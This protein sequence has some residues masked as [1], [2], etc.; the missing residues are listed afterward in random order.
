MTRTT[1]TAA[2]ELV[3]IP[4]YWYKW[5]LDGTTL[6]L[7]IS[8][9]QKEGFYVSYAHA[10]RGDGQGE[11]DVVYVGRYHCASGYKSQTG[12]N[13]QTNITRANART[14]IHNLGSN[15]WQWDWAMN[16]TIKLLYIVEFADWNSQTKIGYGCGDGSSV[17]AMGY[18]DSMLYHTGTTQSSRTTYGLG[19]QY[20]NI[21]GLWDNVYDWVDGSYYDGNGL[22]II[23]NPN[24]FSDSSGGTNIGMPSNGYPSAL[25]VA[26]EL[27]G[28]WIYPTTAGG[29]TTTY[30]PDSWYFNASDPCLR[31]GG[32]Y[33]QN[34]NRGLFYVNSDGT[35][36]SSADMGCRLMKLPNA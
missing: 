21:E 5:D 30:V 33:S 12:V 32:N 23:I 11:R 13:P 22:N 19:T 4:K 9:A 34:L 20:R 36:S 1:D 15:I 14:N 31:V 17:Q 6:R 28:Q 8:D 29:S 10:D 25:S 18:T 24:D 2:G 3:S 26:E 35:S 27:D 16:W 7:Y